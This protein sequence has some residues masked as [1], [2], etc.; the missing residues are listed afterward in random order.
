MSSDELHLY[1]FGQ[2]LYSIIVRLVLAEKGIPYKP[3]IV[4]ILQNEQYDETYMRLN[5]RGVV[6]TVVY[7]GD[8]V[9]NTIDIIQYLDETFTPANG[10]SAVSLTPEDPKEKQAMLDWLQRMDQLPMEVI[11]Y[12]KRILAGG[13]LGQA[14]DFLFQNRVEFLSKKVETAPSD[15]KEWYAKKLNHVQNVDSQ[16]HDTVLVEHLLTE[17][18]EKGSLPHMEAALSRHPFLVGDSYTLADAAWTPILLRLSELGLSRRLWGD[19]KRPNLEAY[20]ERLR[21]R[22]S[23]DKAIRSF[24]P[25]RSSKVLIPKPFYMRMRDFLMKPVFLGVGL[26]ATAIIVIYKWINR[27]LRL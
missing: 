13:Q 17:K 21:S 6:P 2:S 15:L 12:G 27:A 26:L 9:T 25:Q 5:R 1:H 20:Y 11:I 23:Y 7:K 14:A 22:S 19:G 10:K 3:H 18:I 16:I 4:N 24:Q 8:V